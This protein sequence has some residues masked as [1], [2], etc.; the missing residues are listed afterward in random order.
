MAR[1]SLAI[2]SFGDFAKMRGRNILLSMKTFTLTVFAKLRKDG[3]YE[4][5]LNVWENRGTGSLATEMNFESEVLMNQR[6]NS[7]LPGGEN[8]NMILPQPVREGDYWYPFVMPM[9]DAQAANL[10]WLGEKAQEREFIH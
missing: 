9:S 7:A 1:K 6:V 8:V 2:T 10:G 4:Y 5:S 3:T